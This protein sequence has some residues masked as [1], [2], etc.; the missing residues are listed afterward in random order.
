MR[1]RHDRDMTEPTSWDDPAFR[2]EEQTL[3]RRR[4]LAAV[5]TVAALVAVAGG[6]AIGA[7]AGAHDDRADTTSQGVVVGR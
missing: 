5:V 2:T 3:R 6:S 4:L 7:V 1:S